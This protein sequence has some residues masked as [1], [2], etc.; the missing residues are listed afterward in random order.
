MSQQKTEIERLRKQ[1]SDHR[2]VVRLLS[3]GLV[4]AWEWVPG[5][6]WKRDAKSSLA[7]PGPK[8]LAIQKSK[9]ASEA[10]EIARRS[11]K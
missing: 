11:K 9:A 4:D 10:I 8:V 1:L 5:S 7:R 6:Y 2:K 3:E